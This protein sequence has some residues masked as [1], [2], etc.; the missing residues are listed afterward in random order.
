MSQGKV[1]KSQNHDFWIPHCRFGSELVWY[2]R[3]IKSEFLNQF[4]HRGV[5]RVGPEVSAPWF[6]DFPLTIWLR[7]IFLYTQNK[8]SEFLDQFLHRG[9]SELSPEVSSPWFFDSTLSNWLRPSIIFRNYLIR[10]FKSNF[11]SRCLEGRSYGLSIIIF[12]FPIVDLD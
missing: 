2:S 9:V 5:S 11:A 3:N 12:G 4:L 7:A 10:I 1:L 8:K 6:L